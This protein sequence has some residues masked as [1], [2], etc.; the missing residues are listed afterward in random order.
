MDFIEGSPELPSGVKTDHLSS[1]TEFGGPITKNFSGTAKYSITFD[2]PE[3]TADDWLLDL[4][5]VYESASVKVNGQQLGVLW[6]FPFQLSIGEAL[7]DG[8]NTIEIEVT[9]LSA[10][11]IADLD[12]QKVPWKAYYDINYVNIKYLP[13]D[14]S[15]W[16]PMDSGLIGPVNL[17]PCSYQR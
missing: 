14:A 16:P 6:S 2:K 13:F 5:K 15:D 3:Q 1:W 7:S 4:G 11:R 8:Q 12:R 17:F 9:N 10:N